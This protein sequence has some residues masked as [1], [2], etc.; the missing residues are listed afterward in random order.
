MKIEGIEINKAIKFSEVD[1]GTIN[2]ERTCTGAN[3]VYQSRSYENVVRTSNYE[4]TIEEEP[5]KVNID[6]GTV[7]S[8]SGIRGKYTQGMMILSKN[9]N[10]SMEC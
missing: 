2:S 10:T 7:Y 8:T 3:F 5:F 1:I 9:I 6:D 4:L